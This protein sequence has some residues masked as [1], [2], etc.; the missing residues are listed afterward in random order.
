MVTRI[1]TEHV[2]FLVEQ[3]RHGNTQA[4]QKLHDMFR[5]TVYK[6][7][8]YRVGEHHAD[9]VTQEVF[10][11]AYRYLRTLRDSEHFGPWLIRI[12]RNVCQDWHRHRGIIQESEVLNLDDLAQ[13]LPEAS[14]MALEDKLD[15]RTLLESIPAT[16]VRMIELHYLRALTVAEISLAEGLPISTVKWRIH[17]GLELCRLAAIKQRGQ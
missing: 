1:D 5:K 15:L 13:L 11:R 2:G 7:A 3:V 4:F 16:Y 10:Y 8:R 6:T 14:G 17:R 9:D 12:A